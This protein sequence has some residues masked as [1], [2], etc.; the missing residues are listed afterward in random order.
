LS[1]LALK[2]N[3]SAQYLQWHLD[4]EGRSVKDEQRRQVAHGALNSVLALRAI[5]PLEHAVALDQAAHT[6]RRV[7]NDLDD[8]DDQMAG[9]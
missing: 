6:L 3:W 4:I 1:D 7:L 5:A 9:V 8:G 2:L